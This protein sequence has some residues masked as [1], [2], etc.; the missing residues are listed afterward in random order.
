MRA[1]DSKELILSQPKLKNSITRLHAEV[2]N[3]GLRR[4][5]PLCIGYGFRNP[6]ALSLL[7]VLDEDGMEDDGR[8]SMYR[9]GLALQ[10]CR[11]SAPFHLNRRLSRNLDRAVQQPKSDELVGPHK[12]PKAQR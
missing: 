6:L 3:R 11:G 5:P 4:G 1:A 10:E 9:I 7:H 8:R 12:R 2:V